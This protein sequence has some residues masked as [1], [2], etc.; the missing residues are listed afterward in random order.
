M[1]VDE[2][3]MLIRQEFTMNGSVL[4]EKTREFIKNVQAPA[5]VAVVTLLVCSSG[6]V[7]AVVQLQF[8]KHVEQHVTRYLNLCEKKG[9]QR[10]EPSTIEGRCSFVTPVESLGG[11]ELGRGRC[12]TCAIIGHLYCQLGNMVAKWSGFTKHVYNVFQPTF[13]ALRNPSQHNQPSTTSI[14]WLTIFGL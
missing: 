6:K 10:N 9:P 14:L 2:E 3:S 12:K 4:S 7:S 5:R 1:C 11:T 8:R 13:A